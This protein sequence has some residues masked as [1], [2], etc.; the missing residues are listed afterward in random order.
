MSCKCSE[1]SIYR[2]IRDIDP[3]RT[4][5]LRNRFESQ[6]R[7]RFRKIR[8]LINDAIVTQDVF[9]LKDSTHATPVG[10]KLQVN[11]IPGQ[12]AF[13]RSSDKVQAF[14]NWL[15]DQIGREILET[16]S[17]QQLGTAI[18][19]GWTDMYIQD[20]YKRG[21]A[22]ARSEMRKAGMQIPSIAETGGIDAAMYNP[23]H[24]DRVGVLYTRTWNDL[25]NVSSA[26]EGQLSRVLSQSMIDGDGPAIIARKLNAVI[27]TSGGELGLVDALGR[28]IPAERRARMIART[29]TI[30]AHHLA[31]VQEYRNYEVAGVKVQ[32]EWSTAGFDVCDVCAPLHGNVYTLDEV[33]GM[34]PVH[35]NCRCMI[36]P[37]LIE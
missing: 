23:F 16:V 2:R 30:R 14:M 10:Y 28:Y 31:N 5:S 27:S 37:L 24:M 7:K 4:M 19:S 34:I 36:L 21:V 29:E 33:Q 22:R 15:S 3:T 35:P 32:A 9:G 12:F 18:E 25:K 1:I 20:S 11:V 26:M 17:Y 13:A 8:G 6:M